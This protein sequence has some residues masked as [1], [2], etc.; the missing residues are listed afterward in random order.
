MSS[1]VFR[2]LRPAD[3]LDLQVTAVGLTRSNVDGKPVLV[4]EPGGKARL[5]VSF[6]PQ[7]MAESATYA[8][9]KP[10][11]ETTTPKVPE[12]Y[13]DPLTGAYSYKETVA[14]PVESE[15]AVPITVRSAQ[16]SRLVFAVPD[17]ERIDFTT[18]G[19][20]SA[21]RRFKLVVAPAA[22]PRPSVPRLPL[23]GSRPLATLPGVGTLHLFDD[24]RFVL[25]DAENTPPST[26]APSTT[27]RR[28]S[29]GRSLALSRALLGREAIRDSFETL[30]P[31]ERLPDV[32]KPTGDETAIEAPWR[33]FLSPSELGGFAHSSQPVRSL[34][35][36]NL[37]EL[38]H[39]RLGVRAES[40]S[41]RSIRIDEGRH[42]QR[43]VRAIWARDQEKMTEPTSHSDA[44]FRTSLDSLDRFILVR[45]S[46]GDAQVANVRPEPIDVQQ[47]MLSSL[48]AWLNLHGVW[49]TEPYS[50]RELA[51]I[52]SWDHVAPMGR[53]QF[54]RVVYPGLLYPFGHRA[55]LV[56]VTERKIASAVNPQAR[57][58]QRKFLV[59]GEPD[60]GYVDRAFP[61]LRVSVRPL[62]TPDLAD[63]G[64]ATAGASNGAISG[65]EVFWPS[66]A[67]NQKLSFVL[68]ALDQD[69]RAVRLKTPLIFV[70][71]H[72]A[73]DP[74]V[75]ATLKTEWAKLAAIAAGG[76]R[77]SFAPSEEDRSG[78][79]TLETQ[80]LSVEVKSWSS[81]M[82]PR[83]RPL[84][85]QASVVIPAM[86]QLT[87]T[88]AAVSVAYA[89]GYVAGGFQ[90]GAEVFMK[91]VGDTAKVSF[92]GATDRAG[93]FLQPDLPVRGLSRKLGL[94]SNE[95]G[96]WPLYNKESFP[97]DLLPK[98]FG[99]IPLSEILNLGGLDDAPTF[100]QELSDTI[101]TFLRDL[102]TL[103]DLLAQAITQGAASLSALKQAIHNAV[104]D[105]PAAIEALFQAT[106]FESAKTAFESAIAELRET[107][108]SLKTALSGLPLPVALVEKAVAKIASL[109][110]VMSDIDRFVKECLSFAQGLLPRD[111]SVRARFEWRAPIKPWPSASA[112]IFDPGDENSLVLAVEA[113]ASG[114]AAGAYVLA[115]LR[116]FQLNLVPGFELMQLG[117]ERI[118]FR[119][120]TARSPEVDVVLKNKEFL[121]VLGYLAK[122]S[123]WIP[124]DGFSDPPF[125]DVSAEGVR[126]GFTLALPSIA[127]GVFSL[128]NISL[129]S[130]IHVPFLGE[131]ITV[132]FNFCS[133]EKPFVLTVCCL[134]G[135]GFVSLRLSAERL[136]LLEAALEARAQ[137]GVDF[138]VASGSIS[139]AIG[140][141]LRLEGKGGSLT[142]Y[143]RLR[144]E[145]N[146]LGIVSA[147][148]E[149]YL[150]LVY[151][152]ETGKLVGRARLTIEVEVFCFSVSVSFEVERRFAGSSGDPTFLEL[153][154]ADVNQASERW[155]TYCLAFA[156]A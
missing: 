49:N 94:S 82:I 36:R 109:L 55:A 146:V 9:E 79:T 115:E 72:K 50:E 13:R 30:P 84:L 93:G 92:A 63:P 78:P 61:F 20:L 127:V 6:P 64:A 140:V 24:G 121:G 14:Q 31:L 137:L 156:G 53:D 77:I 106:D 114:S 97:T 74:A 80:S 87:P 154:G 155:S 136:V 4:A 102:Q 96:A 152:F 35:H 101:S 44:G 119:C 142:G 108:T 17:G 58:Y 147:S 12:W 26:P 27:L 15:E 149:L 28:L 91:I 105:L 59:I 118:A 62:T 85:K 21:L 150:E 143:F 33:L 120:G 99:L 148:I 40:G 43:L 132:G 128:E 8:V 141:Y 110:D 123:E 2:L 47:L 68:D 39:T 3:L 130:D 138:G 16:R 100:V 70:A 25:S 144:G 81:D 65:Q 22:R 69:G 19:V 37:V 52:L 122:L 129:G 135:G 131:A 153:L 56:K 7:H 125:C 117:F 139:A 1:L 107:L 98:L 38:W 95:T 67:A 57:L 60:R 112:P 46:A 76:Q 111:G 5:I 73:K 124:M 75:Q 134:G 11:G 113:A 88:A 34:Q 90:G 45:Q 29:L 71:E 83:P 18:E 41:R 51:G 48:G 10:P 126:V 54:V 32:R 104:T 66:L 151:E 86:R 23:A 89:D 42:P 103:R 133:R 145:V 116:N